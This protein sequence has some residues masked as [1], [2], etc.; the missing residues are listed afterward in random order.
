MLSIPRDLWVRIPDGRTAT[1]TFEERINVAYAYGERIKYPGGGA[2]LAKR[3]VELNFGVPVDYTA[4]VDFAGFERAIDALGGITVDV[5]AAVLD[6]TYPTED[7][8]YKYVYFPPGRQRMDGHLALMYARSRHADNDLARTRR[9]Q[10]VLLAARDAAL[11]VGV[12]PRLPG[13][14]GTLREAVDTDLPLTELWRLARV[15]PE[16]DRGR[17]TTRSF[18]AT[19]CY[20][21][22]TG[23]GAD[24]LMPR[25]TAI[26]LV[27]DDLFAGTRRIS[28]QGG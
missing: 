16:I 20:S 1:G 17:I 15:M 28:H 2:A 26:K 3:A 21:V 8:G 11:H 4:R 24:I 23:L 22:H 10:A 9:Q 27:V 12:L 6:T 19:M 13:L 7:Y 5:P 14:I 18:D 25:W